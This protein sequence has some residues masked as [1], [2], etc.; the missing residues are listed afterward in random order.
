[1]NEI[2]TRNR[3]IAS[4]DW[5]FRDVLKTTLYCEEIALNRGPR[6]ERIGCEIKL[7][8]GEKKNNKVHRG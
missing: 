4:I 6:Y 5:Q 8:G 2:S 1:M 7:E 3:Q